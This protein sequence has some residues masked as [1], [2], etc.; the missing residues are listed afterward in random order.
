MK[1]IKIFLRNGKEMTLE[2]EKAEKILDSESQIIKLLDETGKWTGK[3]INKS[4][5]ID[6]EP[7]FQKERDENKLL[8][9]EEPRKSPEEMKQ[10]LEKFKPQFIQCKEAAIED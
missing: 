9:I 10:I 5:I 8:G 1:Y 4:E 2:K 3:I 6:T 7:D